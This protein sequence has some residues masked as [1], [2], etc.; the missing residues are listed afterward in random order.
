ML[1]PLKIAYENFWVPVF[2]RV[3]MKFASWIEGKDLKNTDQ[4]Y[5]LR[6]RQD[7]VRK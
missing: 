4:T 2:G 1:N 7:K 3:L 5:D 6:E